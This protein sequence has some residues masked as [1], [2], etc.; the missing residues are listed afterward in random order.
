MTKEEKGKKKGSCLKTTLTIF[1]VFIAL[2]VLGSIFGE[3]EENNNNGSN[4]KEISEDNKDEETVYN[5]GDVMD[6]DPKSL[7]KDYEDNEVRGDELYDGKIMRL[8]GTVKSI[9][10][11]ITEKVYITF[12]A[13]NEYSITAVQCFF[14]D[15]EQIQKVTSLSEGDTVTVVGKCDGK[16]GNVFIKDCIFQ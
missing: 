14:T 8:T 2:G 16:F 10:K 4:S 9:G 12:E 13:E 11:D 15:E 5:M 6:I 7:L 1:A 3:S